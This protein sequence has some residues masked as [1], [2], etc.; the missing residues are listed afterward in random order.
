MPYTPELNNA[1]KIIN[2]WN[3]VIRKKKGCNISSTYIKRIAKKV[4]IVNPMSISL[5]TCE[6]ER[7]LAFAAYRKLKNNAITSRKQFIE[8]LARQQSARGNE[9]VS[10]AIQRINRNEEMRESYRRIK[11]V[12]K[13]PFYGATERVLISNNKKPGEER[14]TTKKIE[15]EKA[16]CTENKKKF[17]AAYSSPFLQEPLITQLKQTAT[18][19]TANKILQGTFR[20]NKSLS[21]A[22]KD[23]IKILKTP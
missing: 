7:K 2:V 20:A 8:E 22:T 21:K 17:T 6:K 19:T 13:K 16:L 9:S 4:S 10:N 1:G 5:A 11:N 23:Y 15:I 3:N 12:T 18:T 14:V